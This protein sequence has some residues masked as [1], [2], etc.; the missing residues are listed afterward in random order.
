M[1]VYWRLTMKRKQQWLILLT[2]LMLSL[3]LVRTSTATTGYL[4]QAHI[5]PAMPAYQQDNRPNIIV[6][7]TDDLDANSAAFMPNLQSLLV[8]QGLTFS[9]MFVS[10]ALCCPSRASILRGQY[11]HNHHVQDNVLPDSGFGKFVSEGNEN[12]TIATWLQGAN[13]R[14]VLIGKYFNGYNRHVV[15]HVPPG[16]DEWYGTMGSYYDYDMS[17]NGQLVVYHQAPEDYSTDVQS[18]KA[19]DFIRRTS[20]TSQPFLIYLA[21]A[22]PH[23]DGRDVDVRPPVPAPRHQNM[24]LNLQAP[25]PPSFNEAD[26][27][28]KP[29][30]IGNYPLLTND[31]IQQIDVLYRARLQS[32]QAVDDMIA[33]LV[34]TLI[35]TGEL[36]HTFIFFTSDNGYHLG[37]HREQM[38]KN[39]PY[40]EDIRV[41]LVVR[42]PGV[43]AGQTREH[44]VLNNDFAP[45]FAELAGISP[46]KFVDGRSLVPLLNSSPLPLSNW[47]QAFLN[48]A[49]APSEVAAGQQK[50]YQAVRTCRYIYVEYFSERE[51]YDLSIDPYELNNFYRSAD[52]NLVTQLASLLQ[53]LRNCTSDNC[54]TAEN[55][56]QWCTKNLEIKR[57]YLPLIVK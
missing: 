31:Q 54:R 47:R 11:P 5:A 30:W 51:L 27:S 8:D 29:R 25:R 26:V 57:I 28:D 42:G 15:S 12:S 41:P 17:E 23:N 46:P 36:D 32:I 55:S 19:V 37:Q 38:G 45:T 34:Q 2:G 20:Q 49:W 21:P 10:Q 7:I 18:T 9:N 6:I 35:E 43:P 33:S 13:Y 48:E 50:V 40:E 39:I 24:F 56:G 52:A 22:A 14:T 53:N 3:V 1:K 4:P 16:W 44:L